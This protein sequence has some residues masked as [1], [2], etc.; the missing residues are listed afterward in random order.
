[1]WNCPQVSKSAGV[2]APKIQKLRFVDIVPVFQWFGVVYDLYYY[3]EY[4]TILKLFAFT[5]VCAVC[6]AVRRWS[7]STLMTNTSYATNQ[8]LLLYLPAMPYLSDQRWK[9]VYFVWQ[10]TSVTL[11][12][13]V[14]DVVTTFCGFLVLFSVSLLVPCSWLSVWQVVWFYAYVICSLSYLKHCKMASLLETFLW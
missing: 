4:W 1:M 6:N 8:S 12:N 7:M 10:I 9:T 14:T 2:G 3:I 13:A 5:F 11:W